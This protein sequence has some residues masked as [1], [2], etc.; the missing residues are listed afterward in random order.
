MVL[1]TSNGMVHYFW[2]N[3]SWYCFGF[4]CVFVLFSYHKLNLNATAKWSRENNV[5]TNNNH[6][7]YSNVKLSAVQIKSIW[8][9]KNKYNHLI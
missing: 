6:E 7:K 9:F 1:P 2:K 8:T 4:V 5:R 3:G